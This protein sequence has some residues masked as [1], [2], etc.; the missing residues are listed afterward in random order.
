MTPDSM[1]KVMAF[2]AGVLTAIV[3]LA[4]WLCLEEWAR[5]RTEAF[6]RPAWARGG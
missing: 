5:R 4:G 2:L 6:F 3:I 1:T